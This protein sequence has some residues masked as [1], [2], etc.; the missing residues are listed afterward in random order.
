MKEIDS[1]KM[2]L[3]NV[4]G[5]EGKQKA[6]TQEIDM[7]IGLKLRSQ[8]LL[9]GLSQDKLG[10]LVG[11]TFQQVQKYERGINRISA[12]RL[13]IFAKALDIS[14]SYFFE[15]IGENDQSLSLRENS[16]SYEAAPMTNRETIE[17]VRAYY[18][19]EDVK[20]R[21]SVVDLLKN[22]AKN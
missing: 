4:Y 11:L 16:I 3:K 7:V 10:Q 2:Q 14:P 13:H 5:G 22:M 20:I 15:G 12:S 1:Q 9:R 6:A 19:I 21:K 17:L 18:Q 8:R